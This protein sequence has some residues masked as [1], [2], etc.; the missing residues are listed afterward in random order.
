M[1]TEEQ[2]ALFISSEMPF[3]I[4]EI[5][6]FLGY[7]CVRLPKFDALDEPVASHPDMLF[8]RLGSGRLLCDGRYFMQNRELFAPYDD[9]LTFSAREL[10]A[11]YPRDVLFD[12]LRVGGT[13]IGR[14][15]AIADEILA[16]AM[17]TVNV[18][19]GYAR[20]SCLL[21]ENV[22][23]TADKGIS[24]RLAERG[25]DTLV[26][27]SSGIMLPGYAEGFIGGASF[28][29]AKSG[30]VVFFGDP[31]G[32]PEML[33][34]LSERGISVRYPKGSPLTDYGSALSL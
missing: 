6:S 30:T 20:C 28:Y 12:A 13:V 5:L 21:A 3:E 24:A 1:R 9:K 22:A 17:G 25:V 29:D 4:E 33:D 8:Y 16:D 15:D 19:Q 2:K 14:L 26:I 11:D 27:P 10:G 7:G 31:S 32:F 18:K 23:V 34:F